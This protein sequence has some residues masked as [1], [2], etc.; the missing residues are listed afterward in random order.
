MENTMNATNHK[1]V[2]EAQWIEARRALP[3]RLHSKNKVVFD[4]LLMGRA[5]ELTELPLDDRVWDPGIIPAGE[6]EKY[7]SIAP[8]TPSTPALSRLTG[9][10]M[11]SSRVLSTPVERLMT[12]PTIVA[13]L[14]ARQ[15]QGSVSTEIVQTRFGNEMMIG[16]SQA[17]M[18]EALDRISADH[19]IWSLIDRE[20]ANAAAG[21]PASITAKMNALVE[22][23]VIDAL[24]RASRA[25]VRHGLD[26]STKSDQSVCI[27]PRQ[28]RQSW[29]INASTIPRDS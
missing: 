19:D 6:R 5:P 8:V 11:S 18:R 24:Y 14:K 17:M 13:E 26:R 2:S 27:R 3:R 15:A 23:S 22:P 1:I 4:L 20:T 10:L 12:D 16:G 7:Q 9:A 21:K 29:A 25:G 28:S